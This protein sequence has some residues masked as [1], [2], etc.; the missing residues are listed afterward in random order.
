[1]NETIESVYAELQESFDKAYGALNRE[2]ARV[3]SGRANANL[4]DPIKVKYYGQLTPLNQIAAIQVPEARM[5]TIKPWEGNMLK[6]IER[7]IQQSDLGLNPSN[8]GTLIR[9]A[10]PQLT[11]ERRK[12]L[13][14]QV[15]RSGEDA[16]VSVRNG[17]R[18]ANA[19]LKDLE[20]ASDLTED[21]LERSLK[22][23]QT[24][25][26]AATA[27]V[28]SLIEAKEKDLLEI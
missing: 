12:K 10:I 8:D 3:R 21:D 16:K 11:E 13:V 9:L 6:E 28:D 22:E 20:K 17:R 24:K 5:I 14:K 7:A 19:A 25:T 1:M 26:D 15:H 23:V 18:D 4:L 27:K 2:L